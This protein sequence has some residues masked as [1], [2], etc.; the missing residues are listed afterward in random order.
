MS[1]YSFIALRQA[2]S[3]N[4]A[5]LVGQLVTYGEKISA[6]DALKSPFFTE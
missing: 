4:F 3:N 5:A 2:T 6:E 1:S